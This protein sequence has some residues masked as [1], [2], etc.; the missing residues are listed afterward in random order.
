MTMNA[1][2]LFQQSNQ[3]TS[4]IR[5]CSLAQVRVMISQMQNAAAGRC[6]VVVSFYRR[7]AGLS[8]EVSLI[9]WCLGWRIIS[10]ADGV[11]LLQR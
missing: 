5:L 6:S 10:L 1:I 8:I 7:G 2:G 3:C 11:G 9:R 4:L